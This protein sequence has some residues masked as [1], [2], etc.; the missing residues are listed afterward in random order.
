MGYT[1]SCP[2]RGFVWATNAE[3]TTP[4]TSGSPSRLQ[5]RRYNTA[6]PWGP[7][8]DLRADTH[9]RLQPAAVLHD[10]VLGLHLALEQAAGFHGHDA[11]GPA[12]ANGAGDFDVAILDSCLNLNSAPPRCA[13]RERT[14][15]FPKRW[16][17]HSITRNARTRPPSDDSFQDDLAANEIAILQDS[18]RREANRPRRLDR[19]DTLGVDGVIGEVQQ[20]A[21]LRAM[22]GRRAA[23]HLEL[24]AALV[25]L[26]VVFDGNGCPRHPRAQLLRVARR[27]L[28]RHALGRRSS[29]VGARA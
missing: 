6:S 25:A 5:N 8:S 13:G 23:V 3:T 19:L 12:G 16:T 18:R 9:R 29:P 27:R 22:R 20:R 2:A 21:A 7:T 10:K 26:D 4:A 17:R 28:G 15:P 1:V 14:R 24:V 11:D